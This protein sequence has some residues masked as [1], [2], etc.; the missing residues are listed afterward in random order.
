MA[1][2]DAV[3]AVP[4]TG[5]GNLAKELLRSVLVQRSA[6]TLGDDEDEQELVET[7]PD[8]G[9]VI[10]VLTK[11]GRNYA[12]APL[13]DTTPRDGVTCLVTFGGRRYLLA[14]GSDVVATRVLSRVAV[15]PAD[16]AIR[17]AYLVMPAATGAF[18]GQDNTVAVF[19]AREWEFIDF[20]IGRLIYVE[21]EDVYYRR[22]PDGSWTRGFGYSALQDGT[23]LPSALLGG[24]D[25]VLWRV[26]NQTTN[27]PPAVVDGTAYIIGPA[28]TG[29]WASQTGKIAHGENGQWVIY[30]PRSGWRA[31]DK[32][33]GGDYQF[34]GAAWNTARGQFAVKRTLYTANATWVKPAGIFK[35]CVTVVAGGGAGSGGSTSSFGA[36]ASAIGGAAQG[37]SPALGGG[38][39]GGDYNLTGG[40]GL[41]SGSGG[42]GGL[43]G[44][45]LTPK[46]CG[47]PNSGAGGGG[48]GGVAIKEI[49]ASLLTSAVAV[50][51]GANGANNGAVLV[52]EYS[53]A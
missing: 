21:G 45:P 10:Q 1:N 8:T 4:R 26:E 42:Y 18:A 49:D 20:G 30:N 32:S 14:E 7:D 17:D 23:V 13:G 19:T 50:T 27:D 15:D 43:S 25:H 28:P 51:V 46:G 35:V 36:Y 47:A 24:G 48:G 12:L 53:Y 22:K 37:G 3:A 44:G 41:S 31:Y 40:D 29:E 5:G 34:D 39:V 52:E 2:H 6:Y 9:A 16:P 33:F 11:F 38:G